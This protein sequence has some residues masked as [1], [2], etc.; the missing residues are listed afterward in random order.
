MT[1]IQK[2]LTG[3]ACTLLLS[4]PMAPAV[5]QDQ[6]SGQQQGAT[7]TQAAQVSDSQLNLYAKAAEKVMDIKQD[8]QSDMQQADSADEAQNMQA[9]A[10]E[11][12]VDAVQSFG[13][14]V[15]EYNTVARAVQKNPA[16]QNKLQEMM[17]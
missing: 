10:Q 4:L 14:S 5:A 12:M 1:K 15:E 6:Y 9:Q 8:L 17:Q 2:S 11:E 7:Q 3:V 13:M 16:M